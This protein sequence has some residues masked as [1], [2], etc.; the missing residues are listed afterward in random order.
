MLRAA[1]RPYAPSSIGF[2]GARVVVAKGQYDA[3]ARMQLEEDATSLLS[4]VWSMQWNCLKTFRSPAQC[5]AS[6]TFGSFN[7]TGT[8]RTFFK[9]NPAMHGLLSNWDYWLSQP[10][11]GP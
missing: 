7:P 4:S 6:N 2:G 9:P 10:G 3:G 5:I 8:T 1:A 11:Y